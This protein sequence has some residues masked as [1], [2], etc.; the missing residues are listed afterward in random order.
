MITANDCTLITAND[1]SLNRYMLKKLVNFGKNLIFFLLSTH[2]GKKIKN[3]K[4]IFKND[5]LIGLNSKG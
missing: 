3:L 4:K 1:C 2:N 5:F